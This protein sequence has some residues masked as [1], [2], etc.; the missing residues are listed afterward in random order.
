MKARAT[1]N[2]RISGLLRAARLPRALYIEAK[3]AILDYEEWKGSQ[4]TTGNEVRN[5]FDM[6]PLNPDG[7]L[8]RPDPLE[9]LY[10]RSKKG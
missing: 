4:I 9:L 1:T 5:L 2:S 8:M 3:E 10:M 7:S 6:R